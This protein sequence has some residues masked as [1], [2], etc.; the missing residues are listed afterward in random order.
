MWCLL[1]PRIAQAAQCGM[2]SGARLPRARSH[3]IVVT[4]RFA[5]LAP[6]SPSVRSLLRE[7]PRHSYEKHCFDHFESLAR[8]VLVVDVALA[9]VAALAACDQRRLRG[10][11][12]DDRIVDGD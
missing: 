9:A 12:T 8:R 1:R 4:R 3:R 2:S 11:R 5:V 6:A 7:G 10:H